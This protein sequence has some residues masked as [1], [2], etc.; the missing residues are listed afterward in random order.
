[1]WLPWDGGTGSSMDISADTFNFKTFTPG[2]SDNLRFSLNFT[3]S[4]Y[5]LI[6]FNYRTQIEIQSNNTPV[7][8]Q[9]NAAGTDYVSHWYIDTSNRQLSAAPV[10]IQGATPDAALSSLFSIAGSSLSANQ[11][12]ARCSWTNNVSGSVNA[13]YMAGQCS[14]D[15]LDERANFGSGNAVFYAHSW[16]NDAIVRF[17]RQ[18]GLTWAAGLDGSDSDRWKLSRSSNVGTNDTI[19]ADANVVAFGIP[20]KLK[21][22]TVATL[23]SASTSGAGSLVYV[24]DASGG[25]TVACSDGANWKVVAA[26]GAT[27]S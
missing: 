21:S 5:T 8:R 1:M 27:V 22:Y 20:A 9:L 16:T 2:A 14:G 10:T 11:Y 24:S 4:N 12:M 7:L 18:S 6:H 19:T 25:P 17:G 23:P 15:M 3:T 26:L 13:L